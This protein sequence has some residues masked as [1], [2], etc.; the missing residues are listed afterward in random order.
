MT[1]D[2][3]LWAMVNAYVQDGRSARERETVRSYMLTLA[4]H[5]AR[6]VLLAQLDRRERDLTKGKEVA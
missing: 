5:L 2:T 1:L 6:H 4:E 3:V